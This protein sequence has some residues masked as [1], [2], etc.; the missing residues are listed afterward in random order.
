M[1]TVVLTLVTAL[2]FASTAQ[3]EI[4]CSGKIASKAIRGTLV[5][6]QGQVMFVVQDAKSNRIQNIL[7]VKKSVGRGS[8]SGIVLDRDGMPEDSL[9]FTLSLQTLEGKRSLMNIRDGSEEIRSIELSCR[10][11][12]DSSKGPYGTEGL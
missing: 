7:L 11:I 3:A 12:I 8:Y 2:V 9:T 5:N 10:R 6:E 4:E 1:K